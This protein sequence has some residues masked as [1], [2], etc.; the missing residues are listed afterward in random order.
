MEQLT[1]LINSTF[2]V[3][4]ISSCLVH[5]L[6][7]HFVLYLLTHD[8]SVAIDDFSEIKKKDGTSLRIQ[9]WNL[10]YATQGGKLYLAKEI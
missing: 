6:P 3:S 10:P 8:L 1:L 2:L 4:L 5:M 9:D 7:S